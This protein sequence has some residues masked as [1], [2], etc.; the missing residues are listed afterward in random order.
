MTTALFLLA[1]LAAV[2]EEHHHAPA[3]S[4]DRR[5]AGAVDCGTNYLTPA[6]RARLGSHTFVILGTDGPDHILAAHR[7]GTPP[8]NYQFVLRVRL[9]AEE[10]AFYRDLAAQSETL[11][12]FTTIHYADSGQQ[13]SRTFFCL[14]DVPVMFEGPDDD[15]HAALFPIHASLLKDAQ[16]EGIFKIRESHHP[17]GFFTLSR[18]EVSLAVYR[19][20][21]E[22][23]DQD[24]LRAAIAADPQGTARRIAHAPIV[25]DEPESAAAARSD[26]RRSEGAAAAEGQVCPKNYRLPRTG[27]PKTTHA[28]LLLAEQPD[29]TVL[30]LH[31]YDAAPHNFQTALTLRLDDAELALLRQARAAGGDAPLLLLD[32]PTCLASIREDLAAGR[33]DLS[34]TLY[35]EATLSP[36]SLGAPL[37]TLTVTS[38]EITVLVSRE[39]SSYLAPEDVLEAV[40]R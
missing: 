22:Y 30:A 16:H 39:L 15:P 25:H 23:L 9:S 19:Y 1:G 7:S 14:Q 20:L 26:F 37:G 18:D 5:V 24:A 38:E 10:M 8:H 32:A 11:P 27:V 13:L 21:P 34:G 35:A 28:F 2:A 3:A 36:H 40:L 17:G 31:R 12:S 29:G 4:G 6:S 33:L